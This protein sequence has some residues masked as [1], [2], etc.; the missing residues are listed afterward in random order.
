V[1]I[2]FILF[3]FT[4][5]CAIGIWQ[6]IKK[7]E[8]DSIKTSV[9]RLI[10]SLLYRIIANSFAFCYCYRKIND[11]GKILP[12]HQNISGQ[13]YSK[14]SFNGRNMFDRH[15]LYFTIIILKVLNWKKKTKKT[16]I[17]LNRTYFM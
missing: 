7:N 17:Q 15:F 9:T 10:K 3:Y 16:P 6:T 12:T 4:N 8:N 1:S 11:S 14:K 13:P 2:A 5:F